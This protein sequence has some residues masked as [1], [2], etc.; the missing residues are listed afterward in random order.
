[1]FDYLK[2]HAYKNVWCTPDQDNQIIL[3]PAR[4]TPFDG[5]SESFKVIWRNVPLPDDDSTWHIY[6]IGQVHPLILGLFPKCNEWTSFE[7][8]CNRQKMICD[9]Y[10]VNGVQ[11]PRFES[12]YI[13][14][15]D[16]NLIIAIKKNSK[17]PF[18]FNN[19]K[20]FLRLYSNQYFN[21]LRANS[22]DDF[23][24]VYGTTVTT[25]QEILDFQVI[26][27]TYVARTGETYAFVNGLKVDSVN[28]I[29]V[30]VGDV[31]EF[32]Y[33]SSIYKVIDFSF[34]DLREFNSLLDSKRKYLLH[35][36]GADN[37][38]I[39]YQDDIDIFVIYDIGGGRHKGLYYHRN[40]ED[41]VRMVTH[42]DYS[43]CVPYVVQYMSELMRR[44][45]NNQPLNN[46]NVY[47]RLQIRKSG[48]HRSL[49]FEHNRIH[50]LYKMAD[51]DIQKAMLGIDSTVQNWRAEILENSHYTQIMRS[52]PRFVTNEMVQYGYG[53]NAISKII[54]DTPNPTYSFS[55][56]I[57]A[58]V[59]YLQQQGCTAYEYDNTG[60]ML[61][62]YKYNGGLRYTCVN[63]TCTNVEFIAGI[64]GN[65]LDETYGFTSTTINPLL[66]HRV[67][68]CNKVSGF[69]DNKFQ[70]VTRDVTKYRVENNLLIWLGST[71]NTY[72]MIRT[73]GRF[74]AY[75]TSVNMSDGQ[76]K[77]TLNHLQR[78]STTTT[79]WVMQV[80]MGELDIFLNGR[81][82]IRGL[83]YFVNFPEIFITNKEYLVNP[84]TQAQ[85]FH[86]RFTGFCSADFSLTK[87]NDVGFIEH[88]LLSNN[89]RFDLRDDKVL[90]ITVDGALKT[91]A[92][93]TFSEHHSGI[94]II[95]ALNGRPYQ[96]RDMVIPM[97]GLT[98][99][100]TYSLRFSSL[101]V[102]KAVSNYLTKKIPQPPRSPVNAIASRYQIFSPF[103]CKIIY[104]L[105]ADRLVLSDRI[106]SVQEMFL[107][108]KSYE[109][110]LKFDPT[111][112]SNKVDDRYVIIHPHSLGTVIQLSLN[113]YRF[114]QTVVNKYCNGLV[115]LS[116]FVQIAP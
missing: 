57:A 69:P 73:D 109:H 14:N 74:L 104:D 42:R 45:T 15:Q 62:W 68:M 50:E 64:G 90:R 106:Y 33:D 107:L 97:R 94:S 52:D 47:L 28:L 37:G 12:F 53:Y 85:N 19:D 38:T 116:P 27:D 23:I 17:I 21:S 111:Q 92:D 86:V 4:L 32:I 105:A 29:N 113:K 82:L 60:K 71:I 1:M 103:I 51:E 24:H 110:L 75:D 83:D 55:G 76:L 48:W 2:D 25:I 10:N 56:T 6:Q 112:E 30:G 41:S 7:E 87:E 20:I 80:P 66:S 3:E 26:Y 78:R 70:D 22:V 88:G 100:D 34:D 43:V 99:D 35:Y 9:I 93:F 81:P 11:I 61:G 44:V 31:V 46:N 18:H 77:L 79:N 91:R 49:T 67:Y 95:N 13:H 108:V 84:V 102:D 8:T 16:R 89:K 36:A 96:I 114:L 98:H 63:A 115:S 5:A 39:D 72:P 54:A 40:E 59:P 65:I 101:N 58:D